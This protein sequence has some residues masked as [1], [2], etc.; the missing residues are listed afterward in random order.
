MNC[1]NAREQ[2][3]DALAGGSAEL[4]GELTDHVHS[5]AGCGAFYAQQA[6]LFGAMDSGLRRHGQ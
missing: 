3:T 2:I 5:C 1:K 6:E 4:T